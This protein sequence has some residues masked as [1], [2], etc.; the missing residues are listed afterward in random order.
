MKK[1]A[2]IDTIQLEQIKKAVDRAGRPEFSKFMGID[3]TQL[4][5]ILN[6]KRG[7]SV[8]RFILLITKLRHFYKKNGLQVD[9]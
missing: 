1:P 5:A 6:G 7:V 9:F 4:S 8:E 3:Y 2:T